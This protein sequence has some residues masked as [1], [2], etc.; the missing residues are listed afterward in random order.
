ML[1]VEIGG[2]RWYNDIKEVR[3]ACGGCR[4]QGGYRAMDR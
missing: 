3:T 2:E 4:G 1:N